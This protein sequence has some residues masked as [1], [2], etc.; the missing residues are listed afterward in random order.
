MESQQALEEHLR[1]LEESLLNS[2][3]RSSPAK[4]REILSEDFF[5]FGSSGN[6][7][8]V[9]DGIDPTGIGTVEMTLSNFKIHL[10]SDDS[11]LATYQIFNEVKQQHTLRS[12]I[13]RL[14]DGKWQM[15]F[16][17]GTPVDSPTK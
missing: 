16:H 15:F 6:V 13:W 12:S 1:N 8:R 5:E 9:K 11:V 10:L 4:L 3:V 7:W 14:R 17:Q 2:E